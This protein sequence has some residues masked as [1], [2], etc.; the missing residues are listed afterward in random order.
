MTKLQNYD[1]RKVEPKWQKVWKEAKLYKADDKKDNKYYLLVEL[2]YTSGDLHI[3]H[4]FAW[5]AP[6]VY[7]RMK[8]MQGYNVL[9]PVGGFDSFG[10]P[11]ENAAI[12]HGIHPRDWTYKNIETMRNQFAKMGPSFDWEREVITCDP[13]YYRWTQWLFLQLYKSGLAYRGKVWS[14]WCPECKTVLANEHVENGCCWRH[15]STPVEQKLVDQWLV[16][17]TD[18]ADKLIWPEN[19]NSKVQ[20]PQAATEG[21]NNWI[22]RKEG[23]NISYKVDGLNEVITIWTSRPD[24]NFGATF[25]VIAPEHPFVEKIL[26]GEIK[27]PTKVHQSIKKYVDKTKN[28]LE[29]ERLSEARKKTGVF[30]GYYVVN[31]LNGKKLPIWISDFALANVGTGALVGVPGHDMRDFEFATEF[32]IPVIRVVVGPDGDSS[33]INKPEQIQEDE[34]SMVNSEFLNGMDIH[35]ATVKM[36]DYLEEKG[37]GKRQV[38]Y[39]LRDWSVSR[40]RYWAAPV[41]MIYCANCWDKLSKEK[42]KSLKEGVDYAVLDS[43]SYIIHVVPDKDLPVILP[44][45]VDYTPTGQAPLATATEWMKVKCPVCGGSAIRDSETLDTY[46]DSAWYFF[47]YVTPRFKEAIFDRKKIND[48]MPVKVYFGG[49]EHI[50]GH[51]LYARF[52]TKFLHEKGIIDFDEFAEKRIHHGIIMGSDGYRMSK[53]R[54]NVVNPDEQV[55]KFGADSVRLYICFLG[56]HDKGGAWKAEG[57]EGSYRYLRR[58]WSLFSA[59]PKLLIKEK[60]DSEELLTRIHKTTLKVTEGIEVLHTNTAIASLMELTNFLYDISAKYSSNDNSVTKSSPEWDEA[61]NTLCKLLAPFAPHMMEEVWYTFLGS[62]DSV[63]ISDWP[64]FDDKYLKSDKVQIIVQVNGKLRA[65]FMAEA[66]KSSDKNYVLSEAKKQKNVIE[67]LESGVKKEIFVPGK[68][69]NFV[70]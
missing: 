5:S 13:D 18:Y 67:R 8:R 1:H 48:W 57:I 16:R 62:K 50:L 33:D 70:V 34:G 4:W 65:T 40:R 60:K 7:A 21:Q 17:I 37:W 59:N 55:E 25:I 38:N 68:L 69:V 49:P 46:V 56:P 63:H 54:G 30:T 32:N 47:R 29:R 58:V 31:Q 64:V 66:G 41:P 10:L 11:A 27:V 26:K 24:T 3:G 15:T 36:M 28:K 14:N 23:I 22:G 6:D 42:K 19:Q 35:K 51:T 45:N 61:L 53:S 52:I 43:K 44:E 9:F 2:S 12:K 39:H 20:W